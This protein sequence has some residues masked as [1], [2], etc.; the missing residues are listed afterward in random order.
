MMYI[1][2]LSLEF[3][4]MLL[5]VQV[6]DHLLLSASPSLGHLDIGSTLP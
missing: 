6:W 2:A 5:P 4:T 3:I 1:T